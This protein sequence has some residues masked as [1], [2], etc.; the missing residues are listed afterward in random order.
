MKSSLVKVK[1]PKF[2]NLLFC[3]INKLFKKLIKIDKN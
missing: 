1:M 3:K 2:S